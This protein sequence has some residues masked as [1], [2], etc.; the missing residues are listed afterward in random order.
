VA[1]LGQ[2]LVR[3]HDGLRAEL[4]ALREAAARGE[5]HERDG[6]PLLAHCVAFCTALTRHHTGED[7]HAF[8]AL[9]GQFPDLAPLIRKLEE[10]HQLIGM[11]IGRIEAAAGT[12][13]LAGE[14]DGLAAIMESHFAFEERRILEALDA[15]P[16][17]LPASTLYGVD[18]TA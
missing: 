17:D 3:V 6:R 16:I 14:L 7:D 2:E 15:L 13:R 10:D 8:P 18:R 4:R 11:V 1:A 9:A 12:P 5:V